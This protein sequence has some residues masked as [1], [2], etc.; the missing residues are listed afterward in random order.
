MK[1]FRFPL[2]PVAILRSHQEM[3][4]R[5]AFAAAVQAL[6]AAEQ[7]LAEARVRLRDLEVQLTAGRAQHFSPHTEAQALAGYRREC[8]AEVQAVKAMHE[9]HDAMQQRRAEYLEAH[10][11]VEILNRLEEKARAAHRYETMREEQAEFDDFAGRR[12]ARR[13]IRS[14]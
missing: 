10:R 11:K 7:A 8:A 12:F 9:A 1:R 6:V 2:R 3:R 5:E 14:A 13:T 4:A